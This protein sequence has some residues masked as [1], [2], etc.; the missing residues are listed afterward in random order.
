M[1]PDLEAAG[2]SSPTTT[3]RAPAPAFWRNAKV[4]FYSF[5]AA[6]IAL[7]F[8]WLLIYRPSDTF[9]PTFTVDLAGH[10]GL[11]NNVTAPTATIDASFNLTLHGVSRRRL[12]GSFGLCQERGTVAVSYAGA[13]LAWGRVPR[14]CVPDQGQGRV[15][16]VA[17]GAGVELSDELRERMASERRSQAVELDVEITL[18]R[19]RL[20]SCRCRVKLDEAPSLTPSSPC[21]VL[22]GG[23]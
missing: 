3:R 13:V 5:H 10:D 11:N 23:W 6:V 12:M 22:V 16:M 17:L 2:S 20:L 7:T 9:R 19:E 21:N 8:A 15:K 1:E 14:F 4:V 18:D